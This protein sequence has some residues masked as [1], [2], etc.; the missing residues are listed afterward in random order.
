MVRGA[1][2]IE[3][4]DSRIEGSVD[5]SSLWLSWRCFETLKFESHFASQAPKAVP[6]A[7][8]YGGVL[9]VTTS[10]KVTASVYIVSL[11]GTTNGTCE[12]REYWTGTRRSLW[13]WMVGSSTWCT[14]IEWEVSL[15]SSMDSRSRQMV[16][17]SWKF[18]SATSLPR[19][20][21]LWPA[22]CCCLFEKPE[23]DR[24]TRLS[25]LIEVHHHSSRFSHSKE[26]LKKNCVVDWKKAHSLPVCLCHSRDTA[27]WRETWHSR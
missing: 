16:T 26:A 3:W 12:A 15:P 6:K 18:T 19:E 5:I 11:A 4:A 10:T 7:A 20:Y 9:S 13:N 2:H 23:D 24:N 14:G 27:R 8:G 22:V 25:S 17:R 1:S 21:P